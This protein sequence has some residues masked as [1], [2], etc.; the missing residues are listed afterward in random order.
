MG[1][2]TAEDDCS[3]SVADTGAVASAVCV[4]FE[5]AAA[6]VSGCESC[7]EVPESFDPECPR[8]SWAPA[9]EAFISAVAFVVEA[10]LTDCFG[11]ETLNATGA[12]E[13]ALI[14]DDAVV[15][16]TAGAATERVC[17]LADFCSDSTRP[18]GSISCDCVTAVGTVREEAASAVLRCGS[19]LLPA[20]ALGE[21]CGR[22]AL[23]V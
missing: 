23:P 4:A 9:A 1:M 16:A 12:L 15:A 22:G 20:A 6:A 19:L 17:S 7:D 14:E 11:I 13:V 18:R 3:G 21:A 2:L 8:V 5:S 10:A